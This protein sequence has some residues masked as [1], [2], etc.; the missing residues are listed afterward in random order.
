MN[1][2]LKQSA[3]VKFLTVGLAWTVALAS[4]SGIYAGRPVCGVPSEVPQLC[5]VG[6]H[7]P[8]PHVHWDL[9]EQGSTGPSIYVSA[10]T[11]ILVSV[12]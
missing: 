6:H 4:V 2:D 11:T 5:A 8:T 7:V 3:P 12:T 1:S 10:P 9:P